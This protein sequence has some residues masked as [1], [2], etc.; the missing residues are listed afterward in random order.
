MQMNSTSPIK[1]IQTD[2]YRQL[3]D[4]HDRALEKIISA[5]EAGGKVVGYYCTY[6][7]IELALAAGAII[8][9]LCANNKGALVAADNDLPQNLCPVVRTLYDLAVTD[10]CPF[11]HFSDFVIA[12]TTCDGKKKVYEFLRRIKPVHIMNLPQTQDSPASLD[13][14]YREIQRLKSA[15]E[16]ELGVKI[17]EE[18]IRR[19]IHITNEEARA[20]RALFDLNQAV[21]AIL[22]GKEL[23]TITANADFSTDRQMEIDLLDSFVN[24]VRQMAAAGYHTGTAKTPRV[25]LTGCPVGIDSDKI[26]DII[27]GSGAL[28]VTMENCG[29]YKTLDLMIDESDTRDPLLLLAEK[30]LK[31]PCSV[32][33]PNDGRMNLLRK[34][35]ADFK[36]DGI[37]DLTWQACHTYN[38]E[39]YWVADICRQ[40]GLAFLHIETN[41][42]DSDTENL[43]VRVEAFTEMMK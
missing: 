37:I 22:T 26:I 42:S 20:R 39:S 7:P 34:M 9:P 30:Y 40:A 19:A 14:W 16:A 43:R 36:I 4:M 38:V 6:S 25:L 12:E 29:G 24:E 5:K 32:M 35:I 2:N 21:P 17:T 27:E 10:K 18:A 8:A 31:V 13:L 15:M 3:A 28:V 23:L 41:F 11:F 33:C 1:T